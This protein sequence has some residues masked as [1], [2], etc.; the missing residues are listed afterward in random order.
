MPFKYSST[1]NVGKIV[2]GSHNNSRLFVEMRKKMNLISQF[3]L[4]TCQEILCFFTINCDDNLHSPFFMI[5]ILVT[6]SEFLSHHPRLGFA[7]IIETLS[8]NYESNNCS[9]LGGVEGDIEDGSGPHLLQ[10]VLSARTPSMFDGL[11]C[12]LPWVGT[13]NNGRIYTIQC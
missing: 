7:A 11:C 6:N 8:D 1:R 9:L 3:R 12:H 13:N 4:N 2:D 10:H 5:S